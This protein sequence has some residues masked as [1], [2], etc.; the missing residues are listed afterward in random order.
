MEYVSRYQSAGSLFASAV[1]LGAAVLFGSLFLAPHAAHAAAPTMT[2][3]TVTADTNTDGTID[4]IT[5][6]FSEATDL[7]DSGGAADGFTSLAF[8]NGCTIVNGA[9]SGDG[10]LSKAFNVTGCTAEDT[11]ITPTATYTAVGSCATNFSICDNA[12]ANQMTNGSVLQILR[13]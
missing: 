6:F 7:D 13:A 5:V 11:S 8:S 10:V 12:D 2:T 9:Y 3:S 1:V 4:R